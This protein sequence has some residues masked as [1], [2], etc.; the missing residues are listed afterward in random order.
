MIQY[1]TR[2]NQNFL[3]AIEEG[4]VKRSNER[5]H[6]VMKREVV[7]SASLACASRT[8]AF[9]SMT[10]E[11]TGCAALAVNPGCIDCWVGGHT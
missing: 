11:F 8:R 1:L 2:N 10:Y 6:D 7:D 4:A 5:C 9:P 3:N